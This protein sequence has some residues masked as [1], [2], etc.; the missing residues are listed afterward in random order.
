MFNEKCIGV[1]LTDNYTKVSSSLQT[2]GAI[3][4]LSAHCFGFTVHSFNVL[5]HVHCAHELAAA[6][7]TEKDKED[8]YWC[9][10]CSK[11]ESENCNCIHLVSITMAPNECN[12]VSPCQLAV[13]TQLFANIFTI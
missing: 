12:N 10:L 6:V 13:N 2:Y 11:K 8:C 7:L 9:Y 4:N 1:K 5:F 3:W